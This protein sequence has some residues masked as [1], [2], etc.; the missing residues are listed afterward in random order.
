MPEMSG[1]DSEAVISAAALQA[2]RG[3]ELV[4][5]Y[6]GVWPAF[7]DFEVISIH[8]ER[9]PWL[10]AATS[11]LRVTFYGFDILKAVED[12][13]RKQVMIE[14]L[15]QGV[16]AL[17]I[18]GFNH[19]NPIIG[20]CIQSLEL[21]GNGRWSV[22]WGGTGIRHE[23]SFLCHEMAVVRVTPLNPFRRSI[24]NY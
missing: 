9:A 1:G 14:M 23:V 10:M 21:P 19:Q 18:D 5:E 15:F 12:P 7:H 16:D 6:F 20:L 4:T 22:S 13:E 8:V 17:K 3:A 2:V 11:D 24:P